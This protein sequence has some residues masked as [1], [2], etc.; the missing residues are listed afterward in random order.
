MEI[1][2]GKKR[3]PFICMIHGPHGVGKTHF[4][5]TF[6]KPLFIGTENLDDITCARLPKI[7]NWED[8]KAQL[9]WVKKEKS[10]K[11]NYKTIVIDSIDG[12]Q[13]LKEKQILINSNELTMGHALG[14][15]NKAWH[16]LASEFMAIVFDHFEKIVDK[17]L[18]LVL[19]CHSVKKQVDDLLMHGTYTRYETKLHRDSSGKG[20][21]TMLSE[22]IPN[23]FYISQNVFFNQKKEKGTVKNYADTTKERTLY[24]SPV[25]SIEAKNRINLPEQLIIP[26]GGGYNEILKPYIEKFYEEDKDKKPTEQITALKIELKSLV[27]QYM[28]GHPDLDKIKKRL[29]EITTLSELKKASDYICKE[30][31]INPYP[32]GKGNDLENGKT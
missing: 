18:N 11:N 14:G 5:S 13:F 8:F 29:N 17:G 1:T 22:W 19:V 28:S 32:L 20:I 7:R 31:N 25:P 30:T 2:T 21:G 24:T 15:Y 6:P 12:I 26:E 3:T 4:A 23:I 16:H 9:N 10:T 27:S